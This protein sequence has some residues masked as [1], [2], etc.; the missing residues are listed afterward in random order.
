MIADVF[1][2]MCAENLARKSGGCMGGT[3]AAAL[4]L[5][6]GAAGGSGSGASWGPSEASNG[7]S[8][9]SSSSCIRSGVSARMPVH[10]YA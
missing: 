2:V 4:C 7:G 9:T 10:P 5:P 6:T 8:E 3:A 1:G